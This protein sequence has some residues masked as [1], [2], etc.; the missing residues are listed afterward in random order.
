MNRHL[1]KLL[2]ALACLTWIVEIPAADSPLGSPSA[3]VGRYT[4]NYEEAVRAA[5]PEVDSSAIVKV[6][7]A[8]RVASAAEKPLVIVTVRDLEKFFSFRE[9]GLLNDSTYVDVGEAVY[10]FDNGAGR[11]YVAWR[12]GSVAPVAR[13]QFAAEIP[14]IRSAHDALI[15]RLGIPRQEVMFVDFREILS[16]TD[17]HPVLEKGVKGEIQSEG[18]T[19]TVLRAVAGV[20]VEGSYLRVSSVNGKRL[21]SL[22]MR[23]PI[24]RLSEATFASG[25]RPPKDALEA[26]VK[27]VSASSGDL[28]VN[29]RMAVV[30]RPVDPARPT[31]F[32]PALKIGVQPRTVKTDQGYR[33]DAGEVFYSDLVR[34]SPLVEPLLRD[35]VQSPR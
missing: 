18:A 22:D 11:I 12:L 27:R 17:G 15:E 25:F 35:T 23:W 19:T 9:R 31:E 33:T 10:R 24:V 13:K 8:V 30:L 6:M 14:A 5:L 1:V 28:A 2:A 32:V 29:V 26:I 16:E 3:L 21:A 7:E 4:N 20:L 34:G